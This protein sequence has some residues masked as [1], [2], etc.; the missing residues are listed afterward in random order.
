[1]P[2]LVREEKEFGASGTPRSSV[3]SLS[4]ADHIV[5]NDFVS[6]GYINSRRSSGGEDSQVTLSQN[7]S[8][9]SH[10]NRRVKAK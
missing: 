2:V 8:G 9:D 3:D 6:E 4:D 7:S 1:M 10:S 5:T